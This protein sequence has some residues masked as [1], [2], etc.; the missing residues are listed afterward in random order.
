MYPEIYAPISLLSKL[1]LF[2]FS[3]TSNSFVLFSDS[4]VILGVINRFPS[5]FIIIPI[6]SFFLILTDFIHSF[7]N[8]I[9]KDN[10]SLI[11]VKFGKK[12]IKY[13]SNSLSRNDGGILKK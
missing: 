4:L 9:I 6:G 8:V 10:K 11:W 3:E 13:R 7:G 2:V 5:G 12:Y 1:L